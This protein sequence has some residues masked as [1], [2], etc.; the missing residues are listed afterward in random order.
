VLRPDLEI[1]F[2][3]GFAQQGEAWQP[4]ADRV[5]ESYRSAYAKFATPDF[6]GRLAELE[7]CESALVGYSLGG[8]LALH[9]ALRGLAGP[10]A[11]VLLG[12]S[13]GIDDPAR[14]AERR[15]ADE[16]LADW[17]EAH[18]IEEFT[19]RWEANPVFASQPPELVAAQRPGRLAQAPRDLAITLRTAGQ[20]A[21]DPVWNQLPELRCPV[22]A[23][24][25]ELDEPYARAAERIATSVRN[26]RAA[27]VPG[28]GHAAHL[29]RPDEFAEILKSFL[30]EVE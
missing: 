29:E 9:A 11:L 7:G 6:E 30:E 19:A 17:I 5:G 16:K 13:A 8:R 4:V 15:V 18:S 22:L 23:V 1:V 20:G 28:A 25:G 2:I 12:V 27:L 21:L 26:G 24:A 10:R 3:P 14:R